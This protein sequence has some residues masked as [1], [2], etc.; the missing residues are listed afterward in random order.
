M[1]FVIVMAAFVA[2]IHVFQGV[3][4]RHKPAVGLDPRGRA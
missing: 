4:A 1:T 3:D 2:A